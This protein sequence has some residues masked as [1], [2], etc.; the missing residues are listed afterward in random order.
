L[1]TVR[2]DR[3]I[4]ILLTLQV[5]GAMTT[6][7]LA[8]R[9]EVSTRT[10]HRD[11]ESLSAIGIPVFAMRGRKGGWQLSEEYRGRVEATR[12]SERI[13]I[14]VESWKPRQESTPWLPL[15]KEAVFAER[16]VDIRYRNLAD[17]MSHRTLAPLGLVAQGTTWYV[18]ALAGE[19]I[20]TFRVSRIDH[21]DMR[22]EPFT[23]P[24][25][26]ALA[27][28]WT[29]SKANMVKRL[30][31]YPVR[32][33]IRDV[34]LSMLR[35]ELR[36]GRIGTTGPIDEDGWHEVDILFEMQNNALATVLSLGDQAEVLEPAELRDE[37]VRHLTR[38]L[39]IYR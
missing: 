6:D 28:W 37:V 15:L 13:H 29:S 9:L 10:I 25:D 39:T 5:H 38:T 32:L 14:D 2:A 16:L 24:D 19:D 4:S 23:R 33:R 27:A 31:R 12:I 36:W 22:P 11:M 7:A 35:R 18:V 34:A 20:R 30:P 8:E 17:E 26:F 21:A 3:L 1:Q